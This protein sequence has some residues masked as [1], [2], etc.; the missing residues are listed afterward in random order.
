M[1]DHTSRPSIR[2]ASVLIKVRIDESCTRDF[3]RK[4]D[5]CQHHAAT[6]GTPVTRRPPCRPG[7]AVFPPP[8]PR[9][10]SLPRYKASSSS[11]HSSTFDFGHRGTCYLYPVEHL[12]QLLPGPTRA[13]APRRL[14][15]V[16]VPSMAHLK[17]RF[18]ARE[19]PL[20]P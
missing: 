10:Y 4:G 3:S 7:R 18:S 19:L 2:Y 9:L 11:I 17:K 13:L 8:V 16:N 5:S 12:V 15:H 14:S 6:V 1:A 20:T